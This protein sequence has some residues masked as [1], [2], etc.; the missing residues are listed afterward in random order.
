MTYAPRMSSVKLTQVASRIFTYVKIRMF[1]E[2]EYI[3]IM[4]KLVKAHAQENK[5]SQKF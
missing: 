2:L 5:N 3:G 1:T 4:I